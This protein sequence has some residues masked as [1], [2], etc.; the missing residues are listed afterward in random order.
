M[1]SQVWISFI[2]EINR[3]SD[4]VDYKRN[5]GAKI[6]RFKYSDLKPDRCVIFY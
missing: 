3:I 4:T 1:I 6:I 2:C 5:H